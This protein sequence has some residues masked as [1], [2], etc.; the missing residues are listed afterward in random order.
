V[1][2][3]VRVLLR[4]L[5]GLLLLLLAVVVV[6][7]ML[8]WAKTH[9]ILLV[10]SKLILSSNSHRCLPHIISPSLLLNL[11]KHCK[12]I[13]QLITTLFILHS[14]FIRIWILW[15]PWFL[16]LIYR[17][18]LLLLHLLLLLLLLL[19]CHRCLHQVVLW[20]LVKH[21]W[22]WSFIWLVLLC[23]SFFVYCTHEVIKWSLGRLLLLLELRLCTFKCRTFSRWLVFALWLP[24]SLVNGY[25]LNIIACSC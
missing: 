24:C 16:L 2:E 25:L 21:H 4:G 3:R 7:W 23:W 1:V 22:M 12:L 15:C 9:L 11:L 17:L 6:L 18:L 5:E 14:R 20:S 10:L 13:I 8:R 19:S